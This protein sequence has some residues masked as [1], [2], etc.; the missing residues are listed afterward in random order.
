LTILKVILFIYW[1]LSSA[2]LRENPLYL[3]STYRLNRYLGRGVST[4]QRIL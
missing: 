2:I 1:S 4:H 3:D